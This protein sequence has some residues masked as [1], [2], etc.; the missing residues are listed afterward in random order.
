M[1]TVVEGTIKDVFEDL[2]PSVQVSLL[3]KSGGVWTTE[4]DAYPVEPEDLRKL[5]G[6]RIRLTTEMELL[7]DPE[8]DSQKW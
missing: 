5:I 3:L 8:H 4:A 6:R 1:K 7:D 2:G